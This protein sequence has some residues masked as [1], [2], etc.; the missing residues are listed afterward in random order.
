QNTVGT[1]LMVERENWKI[2]LADRLLAG[3]HCRRPTEA[4]PGEDQLL[5]DARKLEIY[6]DYL[7]VISFSSLA[8]GRDQRL[9]SLLSEEDSSLIL[10]LRN[11][12]VRDNAST[13]AER[14]RRLRRELGI[15]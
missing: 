7:G 15:E 5:T 13:L 6:L 1:A 10:A 11:L 4:A 9:L 12:P 8:A 14:V 2:E 3:I